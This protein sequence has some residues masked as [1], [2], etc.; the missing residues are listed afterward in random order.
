MDRLL[1]QPVRTGAAVMGIAAGLLAL[2]YSGQSTDG[3]VHVAFT[4]PLGL[5]GPDSLDTSD[6]IAVGGAGDES[7]LAAL[8]KSTAPRSTANQRNQLSYASGTTAGATAANALPAAEPPITAGPSATGPLATGKTPTVDEQGRVDCTGAVSCLLDP[9]TNITTVTYPDGTTAVVQRINGMT[10]IA[11][12]NLPETLDDKSQG[13]PKTPAPQSIPAPLPAPAAPEKPSPLAS[14]P[15][16]T[17]TDAPPADSP[18]VDTAPEVNPGPAAA[19]P[20]APSPGISPSTVRPRV[21]VTKPPQDYSPSR[22]SAPA[23]ASTAQP[24]VSRALEAVKDAVNTV[25]EAV[26]NA[27][28]PG[29]STGAKRSNTN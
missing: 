29:A 18:A 21:T 5:F 20:A 16:P 11:Y 15:V 14:V 6:V 24:G 8:L 19:T 22:P 2:G 1:P 23:A 12:K 17:T 26:G 9:A 7:A 13:Q 10:L 27:V 4:G 28:N 3:Y 25:V